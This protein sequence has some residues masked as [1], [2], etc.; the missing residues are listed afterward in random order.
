VSE[1]GK[2]VYL[3]PWTELQLVPS[4][5]RAEVTE[6]AIKCKKAKGVREKL[7]ECEGLKDIDHF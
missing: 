7:R 5:S 1:S 2:T 4:T 3:V 6:V